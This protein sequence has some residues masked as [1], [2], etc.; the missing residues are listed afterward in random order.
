MSAITVV[1]LCTRV[2]QGNLTSLLLDFLRNLWY[3]NYVVEGNLTTCGDGGMA[4]AADLKSADH[5][6]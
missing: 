5:E 3:N 2:E 6:S 1:P 4:D